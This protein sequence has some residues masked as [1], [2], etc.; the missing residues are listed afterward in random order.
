MKIDIVWKTVLN[1]LK[2]TYSK[3]NFECSKCQAGT[4]SDLIGK[5]LVF[6]VLLALLV[7][8]IDNI[9]IIDLKVIFQDIQALQ[10][11]DNVLKVLIQIRK[12]QSLVQNIHLG[13]YQLPVENIVVFVQKVIFLQIQAHQVVLNA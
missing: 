2:G 5:Y 11:L 1:V 9:S 3:G 10:N 4:H 6:L 13:L 12:V 8:I 7:S